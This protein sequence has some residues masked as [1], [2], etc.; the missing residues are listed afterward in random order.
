MKFRYV[1]GIIIG[2]TEDCGTWQASGMTV[3]ET[4]KQ[5]IKTGLLDAHGTPLYR[6]S[7]TVPLGF[8]GRA[9]R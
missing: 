3:I 4:E 7:E 5:P 8:H 2:P 9:K 1:T 6:V